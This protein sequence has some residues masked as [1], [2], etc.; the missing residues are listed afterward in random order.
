MEW[1]SGTCT[2]NSQSTYFYCTNSFR[3]PVNDGVNKVLIQ[4]IKALTGMERIPER[5]IESKDSRL[6]YKCLTGR[7]CFNPRETEQYM[8]NRRVIKTCK[9]I[10]TLIF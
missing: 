9:V 7:K 10:Q 3:S 5:L 2:F 6:L 8:Y 4:N 1:F